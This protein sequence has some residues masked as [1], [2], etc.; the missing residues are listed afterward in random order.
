M[1]EKLYYMVVV[2][3]AGYCLI[4]VSSTANA[5]YF[6]VDEPT[7]WWYVYDS[8]LTGDDLLNPQLP[9]QEG[10]GQ[11]VT[12]V[13]MQIGETLYAYLFLSGIHTSP[14]SVGSMEVKVLWDN[15]IFVDPYINVNDTYWPNFQHQAAG[16]PFEGQGG[17]PLGT[18]NQGDDIPIFY[19][20]LTA[21]SSGLDT[22][23]IVFNRFYDWDTF[24]EVKA[25][26]QSFKMTVN[27]VPIPCAFWLFCSGLIGLIGLRS[28]QLGFISK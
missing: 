9:D 6:G 24:D 13:S 27:T 15:S 26:T 2:V 28:K 20:E 11:P 25:D 22:F 10:D 12:S 17:A 14:A 21:F 23:E 1:R 18:G 8:P 5:A 4:T 19:I 16:P 7:L 3:F